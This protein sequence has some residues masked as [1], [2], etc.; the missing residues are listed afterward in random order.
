MRKIVVTVLT[1][2]LFIIPVTAE[3][4]LAP[5]APERAQKYM[6][7]D[8]ESFAD[9]LWFVIK[10]AIK[11]FNPN[12]AEAAKL[13]IKLL[14]I[15]ILVSILKN[16]TGISR[17]VVNLVCTLCVATTLIQSTNTMIN[18]GTQTVTETSEYGKI[19]L[20]VMTAALAAQGG[21]TSSATL[22]TG[23][24]FFNALLSTGITK[25]I[26]P[27]V[28]INMVLCIANSAV[29]NDMLNNLC[30]FIKWL[31]TWSLKIILYVFTG[32]LSIT[33][34]ITGTTDAAVLKATKLT[35]SGVVPVVG[36][37]VSDAS[38]TII[39]SAKIVKNAA[40]IYGLLAIAAIWIGPFLRIGVQYLLLKL[41]AGICEMFGSKETTSLIKDFS[42]IMGILVAM[43]GTICLLFL[44]S[45]ICFLKGVT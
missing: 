29:G 3:E 38:E 26:V 44:V 33:S 32:Y 39:V 27:M 13:C 37:I 42:G 1:L 14:A 23:T 30:K 4:Y 45:I 11:E 18:L 6:P 36:N 8:T 28:Y 35:V 12:L 20:P 10:S 43:I 5:T 21:S 24:A 25:L 22:Y 41:L 15:I 2:L 31:M 9:G 7:S 40:G 34:V 16:F 17:Q 19:L